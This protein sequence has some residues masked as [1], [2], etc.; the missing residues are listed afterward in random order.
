MA[1][2][3]QVDLYKS[4]DLGTTTKS[5]NW[6]TYLLI[7]VL[8]QQKNANYRSQIINSSN[9]DDGSNRESKEFH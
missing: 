1:D 9:N 5:R 3:S 7:N 4:K 2:T 8:A 6:V